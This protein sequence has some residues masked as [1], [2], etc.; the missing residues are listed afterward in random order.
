MRHEKAGKA[1]GI[2]TP[3]NN[4]NYY[5]ERYLPVDELR[6]FIE[7]FWFVKWNLDHSEPFKAETLPHP[8]IHIVLEK[9]NNEE[10][11]IKS[12]IYGIMEG[13]FSR[14][15]KGKGEVFGIKFKP[16]A[17]Y[18]FYKKDVFELTN[19]QLNPEEVFGSNFKSLEQTILES[20]DDEEIM[21]AAEDFL[22]KILPE[23]DEKISLINDIVH[24][25]ISEKNV[26][27]I[28]PVEKKFKVKRRTLQRIFK[29]YVG[30]KPKWMIQRYRLHDAA[31]LLSEK[32]EIDLV[33]IALDLGYFD[34]AHF[35]N[36]FKKV[37]GKT[38][39]EFAK[40]F[41]H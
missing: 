27:T 8:S 4:Q 26:F 19:S 3:V 34:Q 23:K 20:D 41:N 12:R 16:G 25:I 21:K 1:I 28:D 10:K 22:L 40:A 5:N 24:F 13:K 32:K 15:L 38:P 39:I 36:D 11:S 33:K 31:M 17:F 30:I 9:I 14:E 6:Y 18:P 29:E 37:V 7:H 2:L 35:H